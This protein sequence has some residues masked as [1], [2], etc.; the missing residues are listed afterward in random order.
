MQIKTL[1]SHI[2]INRWKQ[3]KVFPKDFYTHE[4]TS[5]S[6]PMYARS[7]DQSPLVIANVQ[8]PT[9]NERTQGPIT[10]KISLMLLPRVVSLHCN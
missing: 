3:E 8:T 7:P 2:Q 9:V 1:I 10:F 5:F 6:V 4:Q